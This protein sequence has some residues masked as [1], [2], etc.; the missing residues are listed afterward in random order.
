V[1]YNSFGTSFFSNRTRLTESRRPIAV[2][3]AGHVDRDDAGRGHR[4]NELVVDRRGAL[5]Q[6]GLTAAGLILHRAAQR[7]KVQ[8]IF[9]TNDVVAGE[10][11]PRVVRCDLR[12]R[13]GTQQLIDLDERGPVR[14]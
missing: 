2:V 10:V 7:D 13:C 14:R 1:Q 8:S 4:S 6:L 12:Q 11:R 5:Q 9:V 3:K